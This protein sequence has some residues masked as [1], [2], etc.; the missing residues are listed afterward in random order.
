MAL[1]M[2]FNLAHMAAAMLFMMA[3]VIALIYRGPWRQ[4]R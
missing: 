4:T 2:I 1:L 3:A